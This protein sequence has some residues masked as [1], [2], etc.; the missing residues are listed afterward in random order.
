MQPPQP[1][2]LGYWLRQRVQPRQITRSRTAAL[3]T[4]GE[5]LK[6]ADS[7]AVSSVFEMNCQFAAGIEVLE[8]F[9]TTA[10]SIKEV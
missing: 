10:K 4:A 7:S 5:Q 3:T 8:F 1:R 2:K 6:A 9:R